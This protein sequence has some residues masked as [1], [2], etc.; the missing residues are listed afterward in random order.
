MNPKMVFLDSLTGKNDSQ[1]GF[2]KAE[3]WTIRAEVISIN[4]FILCAL[5]VLCG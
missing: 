4:S 5:C 3:A 2:M 1:E